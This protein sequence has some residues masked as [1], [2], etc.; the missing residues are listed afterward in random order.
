[1]KESLGINFSEQPNKYFLNKDMIIV[2]DDFD[3]EI[4]QKIK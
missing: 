2:F 4:N 1:M 3:I